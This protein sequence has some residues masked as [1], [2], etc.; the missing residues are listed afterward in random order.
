MD[1]MYR[2]VELKGS[3]QL[4]KDHIEFQERLQI[5]ILTH[6]HKFMAYF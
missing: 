3:T 1:V 5:K 4:C 6:L 2:V